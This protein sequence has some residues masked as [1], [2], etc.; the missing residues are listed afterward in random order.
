MSQWKVSVVCVAVACLT[1]ASH[2]DARTIIGTFGDWAAIRQDGPEPMCYIIAEPERTR[3]TVSNMRRGAA[4]LSVGLW[5][6]RGSGEQLQ[7]TF[8]FDVNGQRDVTLAVGSRTFKLVPEG[9]VAWASDSSSDKAIVSALRRNSTVEAT[10]VS[11]RGT[12][13]TDRY[14]LQGFTAAL[15]AMRSSCVVKSGG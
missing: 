4:S 10:S 14:S 15:D 12:K 13:V 2:A 11:Q 6:N 9:E 1:H 8:G 7:A 5:P 3:S